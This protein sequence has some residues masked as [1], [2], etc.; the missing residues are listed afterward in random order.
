MA[1][2]TAVIDVKGADGEAQDAG[3]RIFPLNALDGFG[4]ATG[5]PLNVPVGSVRVVVKGDEDVIKAAVTDLMSRKPDA[6]R[7]GKVSVEY[8]F[9]NYLLVPFTDDI[10]SI[11]QGNPHHHPHG[12]RSQPDE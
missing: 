8:S 3:Y 1:E 10:E 11:E 9:G 12:F 6:K 7:V 2:K 4:L 5:K